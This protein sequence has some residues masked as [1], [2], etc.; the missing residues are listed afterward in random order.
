MRPLLGLLLDVAEA[1]LG[2]G[3]L[4]AHLP[5]L[6][7]QRGPLQFGVGAGSRSVSRRSRRS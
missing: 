3:D 4:A 7:L 6:A 2:I 5:E 1:A